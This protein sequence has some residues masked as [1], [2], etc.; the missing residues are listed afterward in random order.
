M[1]IVHLAAIP[2]FKAPAYNL[3]AVVKFNG[4][5]VNNEKTEH[6]QQNSTEIETL[7]T[8]LLLVNCS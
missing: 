8:M 4:V 6:K 2:Q 5:Q 1:T 7:L 3:S